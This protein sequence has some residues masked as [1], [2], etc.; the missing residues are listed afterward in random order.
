MQAL[1]STPQAHTCYAKKLASYALQRDIV[2]TDMPM[3]T[4]LTSAS[5]ASTGS[6]KQLI[7]ELVSNNAFRT[8]VGG[9]P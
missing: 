1:A 7:I 6:V 9:T 4:A 5:M 2:A 8:R 3:L